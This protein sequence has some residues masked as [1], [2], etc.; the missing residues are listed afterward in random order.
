MTTTPDQIDQWRQSPSEHEHLEFKEARTQFDNRRLYEYCVAIANE[1]GGHLLLGVSNALPRPVVGTQAFNDPVAMAAKVFEMVGFRV[2]MEEVQHP[3]GRVVVCHIPSRPRGSAYHLEGKYLMRSGESLVP[4]SEDRLRAIFDEGRPDWLAEAARTDLIDAGI[5]ELLDTQAYFDLLKLPYPATREGVIDRLTREHLIVDTGGAL[6]ITNLGALLFAKRLD[7]FGDLARKAPRVIVYDGKGKLKTK[8]DQTGTKGYAAA[9]NG[10]VQFIESQTPANEVIVQALRREV[11]M[12][13]SI[14]IRETVA[15]ALIHQ[16]L[17]QGG[18]SVMIEVFDDR[19]EVSNPG[20]PRVQVERFID[21]YQS[22]NERLADVM[23][24]LGVCEEKGSGID[25]V[26]DAA[27]V[28]QLPAPEFLVDNVRTTCILH[29]QRSFTRMS[30]EDRIRA[31]YQHACL[32]Y[33]LRETMSNQSLRKRFGLP[34]ERAETVSRI[35]RDTLDAELI[36]PEDSA[37]GS[38]KYARYVPFW[39]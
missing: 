23:R 11:P 22:R 32:R 27:E 14:M 31:C 39:A 18:A 38:K 13:P 16:D 2:D 12:F 20:K 4:M 19:I 24:R 33:V 1:G 36:K 29:G 9:F 3:Q 34:D 35:L 17:Q 5:V 15:N 21:E 25:K 8:R 26:V 28:Y 37:G 6:A 7:E 30:R 10:L